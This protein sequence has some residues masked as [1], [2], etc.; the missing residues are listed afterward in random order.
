[1]VSDALYKIQRGP[2]SQTYPV[3][4]D[5]A[6]KAK[7]IDLNSNGILEDGEIEAHL[8]DTL[9]LAEPRTADVD[10]L[11]DE[12]KTHLLKEKP[13]EL[14]E[15]HTYEQVGAELADLAERFPNLCER[16]SLGQ[17]F[18]GREV[19]ALRISKNANTENSSDRTGIVIT[20]CHHA[21]EWMSME[22]PLH[23]AHQLVEGYET[24]E[25]M[26]NRVDNSEIWVV[27]LVNP[28]GYEY[29]RT[30]DNWWR[31]NRRPA[32]NIHCGPDHGRMGM[33][34]D[35][36]RNYH[37]GIPGHGWVYRDAGD[38][39]CSTRDDGRATSDNPDSDTYR[40]PYGAS[41]MEVRHLLDLELGRGNV[42]GILDH[43]GYGQMI[44]YPWGNKHD[45][46]ENVQA[47]REVG[48]AMN[49]A[50]QDETYRLMQS[51]ELYPTTGG[52]HDIHHINGIMSFTLEI[53]QSFQPSRSEIEPIRNRVAR[54]NMEFIDQVIARNPQA[55]QATT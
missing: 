13:A 6:D 46:V 1:M 25:A 8:E 31:K 14:P 7:Q 36:N 44:L 52:S 32:S 28:D 37:D 38:D 54:A 11:M 43:H 35:L 26:R 4:P 15:Y 45:Q 50:L 39:P 17:T 51:I 12:F 23:V 9:V 41:E 29:S 42:K 22:A 2:S 27:P 20:G 53:G 21:R 48:Q 3:H 5:N 18:E 33:G 24:D 55:E 40:G 47:Y 30:T 34:V 49:D 10:K 19:W 16:V